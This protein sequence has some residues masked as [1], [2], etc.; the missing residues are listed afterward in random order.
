MSF[1]TSEDYPFF[2]VC[3]LGIYSFF[4]LIETLFKTGKQ[5]IFSYW[6]RFLFRFVLVLHV[7][8][9]ILA[10]FPEASKFFPNQLYDLSTYISPPL[11]CI[12]LTFLAVSLQDFVCYSNRQP[13]FI[14]KNWIWLALPFMVA[15]TGLQYLRYLSSILLDRNIT[16]Y[17]KIIYE[18]FLFLFILFIITIPALFFLSELHYNDFSGSLSTKITIARVFFLSEIVFWMASAI[19]EIYSMFTTLP[20]G[21]FLIFKSTRDPIILMVCITQDMIDWMLKWLYLDE[22]AIIDEDEFEKNRKGTLN[23]ELIQ[24]E[25]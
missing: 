11:L 9:H 13:T 15:Q 1:I 5:S 23:I 18:I 19:F 8:F 14:K 7:F 3:L 22:E 25:I 21:I 16:Q 17:C 12:S 20:R 6:S 10:N 4:R 2:T 24:S